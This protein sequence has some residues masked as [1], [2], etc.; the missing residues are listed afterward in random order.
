[1]V[2]TPFLQKL[3]AFC[4]EFA[5]SR[6]GTIP[7]TTHNTP[8]TLFVAQAEHAANPIHPEHDVVVFDHFFIL[9]LMVCFLACC[10]QNQCN[11]E[12][13][14]IRP[15]FTTY[16]IVV[17]ISNWEKC[18]SGGD[19]GDDI[20]AHRADDTKYVGSYDGEK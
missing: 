16:D 10:P 6:S 17:F 14:K 15:D 20:I 8:L 13:K 12:R 5:L 4:P 7:Y 9:V 3:W 19:N 11:D 1:M 2:V 18:G